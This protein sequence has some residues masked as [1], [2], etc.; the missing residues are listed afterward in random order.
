MKLSLDSSVMPSVASHHEVGRSHDRLEALTA[1]V[2]LH[3]QQ[4]WPNRSRCGAPSVQ[5]PAQDLDDP[6]C[7]LAPGPL[8]RGK[9]GL[10]GLTLEP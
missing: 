1:P 6:I 4:A 10:Q 2:V 8:A 5:L 9:L 3:Y 7:R